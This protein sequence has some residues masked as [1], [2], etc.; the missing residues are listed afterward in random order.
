MWLKKDNIMNNNNFT[1][2]GIA[3]QLK[4]IADALE[5][6]NAIAAELSGRK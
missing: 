1:L 5:E 6:S 4:R 2:I 3:N